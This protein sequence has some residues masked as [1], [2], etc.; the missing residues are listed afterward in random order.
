MELQSKTPV[1]QNIEYGVD[2]SQKLN[3]PVSTQ[4]IKPSLLEIV[5]QSPRAT[6]LGIWL[7]GVYLLL[8]Y[9]VVFIGT[10]AGLPAFK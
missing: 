1:T 7:A 2:T 3:S 9:E 4:V 10:V 5:Q 6:A 8:G